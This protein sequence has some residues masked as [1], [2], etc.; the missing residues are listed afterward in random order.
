MLMAVVFI[1]C[2]YVFDLRD[3]RRLLHDYGIEN[4]CPIFAKTKDVM[5]KKRMFSYLLNPARHNDNK[6]YQNT[7]P[8]QTK[9]DKKLNNL[10]AW[11]RWIVVPKA[12]LSSFYELIYFFRIAHQR[13]VWIFCRCQRCQ[14]CEKSRRSAFQALCNSLIN[15]RDLTLAEPGYFILKIPLGDS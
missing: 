6:P 9:I 11:T 1:R 8:N 2:V 5:S 15:I 14:A 10:L 12:S 3:R 7:P 4:I 13:S